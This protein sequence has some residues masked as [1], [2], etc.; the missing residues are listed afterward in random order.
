MAHS[1]APKWWSPKPAAEPLSPTEQ[2]RQAWTRREARLWVSA[3]LVTFLA[4][5][6]ALAAALPQPAQPLYPV[7]QVGFDQAAHSVLALLL[8]FNTYAV[9]QRWVVRRQRN[10]LATGAERGAEDSGADPQD[11]DPLT[12]FSSP[13]AVEGRLSKELTVA[14]RRGHPLSIL[15]VGLEEFA[16]LTARHGRA[17]G[18]QALREFARQIQ[19]ATRG[20]DFGARLGNEG[21]LVALPQCS[22]SEVQRV[23]ARLAPVTL[24][25]GGREVV[26]NFCCGWV[27]PDPGESARAFL[28]RAEQMMRLYK[29]AVPAA[30]A[31]A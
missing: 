1:M 20:S 22:G 25:L 7:L 23:Q 21:F 16:Q 2:S 19:R 31:G 10:E 18:D 4:L 27:D 30:A 11:Q 24:H 3:A 9:Y 13:A 15:F 14:Q 28:Q 6:A 29:D 12:G 5:V 8:L 26:V 17:A